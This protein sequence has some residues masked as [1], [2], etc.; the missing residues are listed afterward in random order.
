MHFFLTVCDAYT[1]KLTKL[2]FRICIIRNSRY[3][4]YCF[5]DIYISI[6]LNIT[7]AYKLIILYSNYHHLS[8]LLR[9]A[10]TPIGLYTEGSIFGGPIFGM[11]RTNSEYGGLIHAGGGG[12][13]IRRLNNQHLTMWQCLYELL[14]YVKCLKFNKKNQYK[15][16]QPCNCKALPGISC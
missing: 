10:N 11:A 14:I 4:R 12:A 16:C 3:Y 1:C 7:T 5:F 13:Y 15:I 8:E 2:R 9:W 6:F